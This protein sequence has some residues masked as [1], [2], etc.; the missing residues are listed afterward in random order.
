MG[1]LD[2]RKKLIERCKSFKPDLLHMQ[3][4]HTNLIDGPTIGTIR[5]LLPK[6]IVVNW[7]GDVRNYIP[8]TYKDVAKY[9]HFNLI[10]STGQIQQFKDS[11]RMDVKY[12]QI[13]YNPKLYYKNLSTPDK[14][15]YDVVFIANNNLIEN[16]PGRS[17]REQVCK[18]LRARF[19][20]RFGLFGNNW[21]P[22]FQS[23]GSI[24]QPD[25]CRV[26][27][28]S[29]C[30]L[31]VSHYN[32]LSHYFSDR[33]LMCLASGR[34][35]VSLSFPK[36]QSYFTDNSDIIMADKIEDIPNK[37]S[38]LL[39]N[40]KLADFIGDSGAAKV[41]AEHTYLSRIN[42]LLEMVGLR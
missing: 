41:F 24:A 17:E 4:Q 39:N 16:Y 7:T 27:H 21:S 40:P 18:L 29:A 32:G 8:D 12:W 6:L 5:A 25:V 1:V 3:I 22:E 30:V 28:K 10:S 42:E 2:V 23:N 9:S 19:G 31:S 14:F 15:D 34:P 33:L 13:G 38:D 20:N 36:W 37:V 26:Y 11:L 35:T